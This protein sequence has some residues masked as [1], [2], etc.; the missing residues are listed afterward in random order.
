MDE[1]GYGN[2]SCWACGALVDEEYFC[3]KC[4][5][6]I[7]PTC[8]KGVSLVSRHVPDDHVAEPYS[9]DEDYE[10]YDQQ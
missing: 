2:G 3:M 1:I 4:G 9:Y 6:Y 5:C 10:D 7:C 8:D